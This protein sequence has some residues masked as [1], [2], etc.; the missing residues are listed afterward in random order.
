MNSLNLT[1]EESKKILE[2]GYDFSPVCKEFRFTDEYGTNNTWIKIR[3]NLYIAKTAVL[4]DTNLKTTI[5]EKLGTYN[6][7]PIIPTA[8]IEK[9]LPT[10][11]YFYWGK[12]NDKYFLGEY[13]SND[14]V[15]LN[16]EFINLSVYE[17]FLWCHSHY[18]EELDRKFEEII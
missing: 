5:L 16:K 7:A 9:C 1:Y 10:I 15:K 11:R 2:L 14:M 18:K 4:L 12:F 17:I 3:E 6:Y 8:V 13:L